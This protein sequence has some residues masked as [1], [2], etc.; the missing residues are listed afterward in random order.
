MPEDD[1]Q[2]AM[3]TAAARELRVA[4]DKMQLALHEYIA[5]DM[6]HAV[7]QGY[8]AERLMSASFHV[9]G[10]RLSVRVGIVYDLD[11]SATDDDT[12][13]LVLPTEEELQ[14][15]DEFERD[16]EREMTQEEAEAFME[17]RGCPEYDWTAAPR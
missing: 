4:H 10:R 17:S 3:L 2:Q 8:S 15:I 7:E 9:D 13:T 14:R 6:A 12:S 5:A 11:D 1:T 16:V